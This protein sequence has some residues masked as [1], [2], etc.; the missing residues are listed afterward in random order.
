MV[1]SDGGTRVEDIFEVDEIK[2]YL[3]CHYLSPCEAVWRLF[4]YDIHYSKPSVIKLSFHLPNQQSITLGDSQKLPAL[5]KRES[6]KETMFTQWFELN[7]Q[8]EFARTLTYAKLPKHYVWNQDAKMWTPRKLRNS[9][10]RI[11]YSNPASGERY[12][13]RMLLNIVKGPRSFEEIRTVDG[14]LHPTFKDACFA[15]GLALSDD[16]LRKKRKLFNFPDLILTDAQL[17]NYCLV[18]IQG[19]LNKNGKSLD[20]YPDLPQPDPSMLTQ[21]DNRMIREELNYNIKDMHILHETLFSSLNPEQLAIYHWVMVI[22]AVTQKKGG[23][24]FLYSPGGTGKTFLYTDVLAKLRAERMI[25]LAVAS[26]GIFVFL[27]FGIASL[28]L[29]GGRTA[30]SRFVIPLELME[31]KKTLPDILG[32]KDDANRSKLFGGMPILLGGDFRKILPVIPKGKRQDI[33][34]VLDVGEGKV[35]ARHKDGEDEPTWIKIPDEYIVRSKKSPIETIV[36]TIFPDYT[37][38]QEDEEYIRERA[39]LTPRNDDADQINK[40]MFKKLNGATMTFKS[41]DEICK[42]STDNIEQ[43]HSYPIN[44]WENK[45][46]AKPVSNPVVT[47]GSV[48]DSGL[49]SGIHSSSYELLLFYLNLMLLSRYASQQQ[50]ASAMD[51]AVQKLHGNSNKSTTSPAL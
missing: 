8:D 37:V 29:P 32:A 14:F 21:M 18:E 19:I 5:L 12:Y 31:N 22:A 9:I 6:I 51:P 46:A 26:S 33:I 3:D 35:Q 39:I 42:G 34:Q 50:L 16:I 48:T 43:H 44:I 11:V 10:G 2:N 20:D 17:K 25:V 27:F 40:H 47:C 49:P 36:D 13:L 30:H 24:F 15:Y 45:S 38:R 4:S 23:L 7:K 28:L 1:P 41:S